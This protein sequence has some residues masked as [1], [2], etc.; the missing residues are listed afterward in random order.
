MMQEHPQMANRFSVILDHLELERS[1]SRACRSY[2]LFV[3]SS[4]QSQ[5][6]TFLRLILILSSSTYTYENRTKGRPSRAAARS[7]DV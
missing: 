2:P 1:V 5:R 4:T 7:A 6:C 3:K